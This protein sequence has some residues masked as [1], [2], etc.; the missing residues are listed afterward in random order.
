M[1]DP[2]C[3][4]AAPDAVP[5]L[6]VDDDARVRA[7]LTALVESSHELRLVAASGSAADALVHCG[8]ADGG[9]PAVALVDVLLP[10]EGTGTRLLGQLA[11]LGVVPVAISARGGLR[12][13]ALRAGAVAFLEKGTAPDDVVAA[14]V[15]HAQPALSED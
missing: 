13:A 4:P 15:R 7:A 2:G 8:T 3:Q 14:L 5:V 1:T 9:R 12:D 10:D 6:V 11:A